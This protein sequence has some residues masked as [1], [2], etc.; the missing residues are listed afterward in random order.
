MLRVWPKATNYQEPM[1]HGSFSACPF[2]SQT[3]GHTDKC[4][5]NDCLLVLGWQTTTEIESVL[6]AVCGL[7]KQAQRSR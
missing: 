6:S 7:A 2:F 3:R 4:I 1:Q 5:S